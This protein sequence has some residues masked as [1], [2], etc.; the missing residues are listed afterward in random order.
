MRKKGIA[1]VS[2]NAACCRALLAVSQK[3]RKE[4]GGLLRA[5]MVMGGGRSLGGRLGQPR[6]RWE[7]W[8][9]SAFSLV[10]CIAVCGSVAASMSVPSVSSD[11]S[12]ILRS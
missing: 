9:C 5:S 11:E 3:S 6:S 1:G 12:A 2:K 7:A 10:R 4:G 8:L